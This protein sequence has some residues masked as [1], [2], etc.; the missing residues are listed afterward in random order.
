METKIGLYIC[1]GCEIG[2]CIDISALCSAITDAEVNVCTSHP[3]LCSIA[4]YESIQEGIRKETLNSLIIAA[5]SLREK[6]EAF[7]FAH[8]IRVE[9]VN[10]R[11]L[12][13]WG[14]QGD[15]VDVQMAAADYIRMGLSKVRTT[16]LPVP[17]ILENPERTILVVGGGI[18]GITAAIEG[19][20]A[21]YNIHLV[22]KEENLGGWSKHLHRQ[23][24]S[25]PPYDQLIEPVVNDAIKEI[26]SDPSI[27][28]YLNTDQEYLG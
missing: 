5:C 3:A 17:Y 26:K 1:S 20:K 28:S 4:G 12:V 16:Q 6:T 14:I 25:A 13:A 11:E 21:G 19:A 10:I 22:E 9:R 8:E 23:I 18:T 24:P 2:K 27:G 15:P 7:D